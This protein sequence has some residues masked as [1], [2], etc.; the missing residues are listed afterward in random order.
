MAAD[1]PSKSPTYKPPV[2]YS[3]T[4]FYFGGHV[5]A[6]GATDDWRAP[7]TFERLGSGTAPGFL[8][9]AQ[10][11]VNYQFDAIVLGL[12][13]D[14]SWSNLSGET[15]DAVQDLI[16]CNTK[17]DRFATI[18][19][20]MGI[21][22]DRAL[23]YVKGG[24]AWSHGLREISLLQT[25]ANAPAQTVSSSKQGWT[26]GAGIE[27]ALTRNWS[28]KLEYDFMDFGTSH[29]GFDFVASLGA[30]VPADIKERIHALKFGFNYRFD[31]S[32]PA[33]Y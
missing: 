26:A 30:V 27:Y 8:G 12:E 6:G 28:A 7:G 4:G 17:V 18:A 20:R 9:G 1:I 2:A 31:W 25:Q 3:W 24:A 15:C 33:R 14:F 21:A 19:G 23:V 29:V 5:G 10:V 32:G 13:A 11:G 16:K 22:T